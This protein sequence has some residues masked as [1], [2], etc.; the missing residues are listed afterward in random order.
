LAIEGLHVLLSGN[1]QQAEGKSE[2]AGVDFVADFPKRGLL[3]DQ[4]TASNKIYILSRGI[5]DH[6]IAR[7]VV[8]LNSKSGRLSS[9]GF[10]AL[11]C[12]AC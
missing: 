8:Q 10:E 11:R 6:E 7:R 4:A 2:L 5:N 1:K 9:L 3:P 12:T